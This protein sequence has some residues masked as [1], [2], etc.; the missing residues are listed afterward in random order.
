[1]SGIL[2][3]SERRRCLSYNKKQKKTLRKH[4]Q[5]SS[6]EFIKKSIKLSINY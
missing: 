2:Y 6:D 3:E 5:I 4:D 1:M